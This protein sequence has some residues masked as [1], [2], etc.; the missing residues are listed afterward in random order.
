MTDS[1]EN[2]PGTSKPPVADK[3]PK[4]AAPPFRAVLSSLGIYFLELV[5]PFILAAV[6][7]AVL[8]SS[9]NVWQLD[10]VYALSLFVL[11]VLVFSL[12][13]VLTFDGVMAK[14]RKVNA[15]LGATFGSGARLRLA[16]FILGGA[17]IPIALAVTA[18]FVQLPNR[19]TPIDLLITS[20]LI[21]GPTT[22]PSQIGDI[23][24]Q[25][26][27]ASTR[28]L[29][30]NALGGFKSTDAL[31]QLVRVLNEKPDLLHD[32]QTYRALSTAIASYGTTA[33][34]PLL[35]VFGK[36]KKDTS[37]TL[38]ADLFD[39]Y[40]ADSFA[41]LRSDIQAEGGDPASVD[42]SLG[43]VTTAETQL[44]TALEGI[45]AK[46]I[47]TSTGDL[48]QQFILQTF[49]ETTIKDDVQL[50]NLAKNIAGD[51]TYS[52]GVR[53]RA[54]LLIAKVGSNNDMSTLYALLQSDDPA[55]QEKA[56]EAIAAMQAKQNKK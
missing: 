44:K 32:A 29:A 39:L 9:F 6:I 33:K 50:L 10:R 47:Q 31:A 53:G 4:R 42:A 21:N 55:I 22:P 56:L 43:Q 20:Q 30:I 15:K 35:A 14:A 19:Q 37:S 40:F 45:S 5:I 51:K 28:L 27:S 41:G 16:K 1:V 11:A 18:I 24:L 34:E 12:V 38:D 49:L 25:S 46:S 7:S 26:S 3:K 52:I 23:V 2:T 54:M 17:V 36:A 13:S 48:R 8:F